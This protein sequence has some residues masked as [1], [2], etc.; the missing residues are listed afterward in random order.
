M[1]LVQ[2]HEAANYVDC[3]HRN[4]SRRLLTPLP[5]LPMFEIQRRVAT[6][7]ASLPPL[8]LHYCCRCNPLMLPPPWQ[9]GN[10]LYHLADVRVIYD[11]FGSV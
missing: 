9:E 10:V 6:R 11:V 1:R 5:R 4:Y 3:H 7:N 8:L 2:R